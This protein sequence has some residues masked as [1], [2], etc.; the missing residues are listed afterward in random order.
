MIAKQ[1][2]H[3]I[4]VTISQKIVSVNSTTHRAPSAK[5]IYE[6]TSAEGFLTYNIQVSAQTKKD[7][8]L[9]P[10]HTVFV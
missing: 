9:H 7:K 4:N 3:C 6:I 10:R 2:T 1:H 5:V 8:C